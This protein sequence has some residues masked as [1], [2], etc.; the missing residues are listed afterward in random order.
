[1]ATDPARHLTSAAH[2]AV[3]KETGLVRTC[4][5]WRALDVVGDVSSLLVLE[6]VWLR[7]HRF[8]D[9][10]RRTALPK[11]V[12]TDRL[13]RL[14]TLELLRKRRRA[15]SSPRF[16]YVLTQKGLDLYPVT[17]MLH[18]WERQ[19]SAKARTLALK[20]KHLTCGRETIPQPV[21]TECGQPFNAHDVDWVPGPG[22]GYMQPQYTRR[23]RRRGVAAPV[24]GNPQ[25]FTDSAEILGDRWGCLILRS[26]FTGL[27][28]HDEL[29]ADTGMATNILAERLSWLMQ[30]DAVARSADATQDGHLEYR[31]TAK[32]EDFFP[33]LVM[34]QCWGDRHAAAPEGQPITFIHRTCGHVLQPGIICSACDEPLGMD[35]R[36]KMRGS[37]DL[38]EPAAQKN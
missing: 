29:L 2:L 28:R 9:I 13:G 8:S 27:H 34:L 33:V 14:V 30:I 5:L 24:A 23:R 12:L 35:V 31:L 37:A 11:A 6:A 4:S 16:D 3:L 38:F 10:E 19:W 22:F 1:M 25:L 21:C 26:L 17:L 7:E 32:G 18:R 20:L 15:P 36:F